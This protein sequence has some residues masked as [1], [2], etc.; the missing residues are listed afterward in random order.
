MQRRVDPWAQWPTVLAELSQIQGEALSQKVKW[1]R[2]E[3]D[4]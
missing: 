1:N 2:T 3:K 4:T